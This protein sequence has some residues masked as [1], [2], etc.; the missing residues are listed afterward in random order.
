MVDNGKVGPT[1]R[2]RYNSSEPVS[3]SLRRSGGFYRFFQNSPSHEP[4]L[5]VHTV[6]VVWVIVVPAFATSRH[7]LLYLCLVALFDGKLFLILVRE[8]GQTALLAVVHSERVEVAAGSGR[9][10][11]PW[12]RLFLFLECWLLFF[13]II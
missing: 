6:V 4:L 11:N 12:S 9:T 5:T 1:T 13:G 2:A 8:Q 3:S 10:V 7:F